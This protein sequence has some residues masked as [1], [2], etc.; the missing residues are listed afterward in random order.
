MYVD[1]GGLCIKEKVFEIKQWLHFKMKNEFFFAML[2]KI[3]IMQ[4]WRGWAF[5]LFVIPGTW[6]DAAGVFLDF[7]DIQNFKCIDTHIGID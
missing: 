3:S 4:K 2:V 6:E 5:T 7:G 1:R